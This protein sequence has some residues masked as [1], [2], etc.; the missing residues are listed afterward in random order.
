M[1]E[2]KEPLL[3]YQEFPGPL[4]I[5][6]GPGTGK[7]Y[8]LAMRVKFLLEDLE[9]DPNEIAVITF[10]NEAARNMREKLSEEDIDIPKEKH[11]EIISTMHSL[12]NAIIMANPEKFGFTKSPEVLYDKY[13]RKV[14][15]SDAANIA[16]YRRSKW[17][18]ADNCRRD[19]D[20]E[21]NEKEEKCKICKEYRTIMRKCALIDYDD[22]IMLACEILRKDGNLRDLWK[23]RTRYLLVD[24]YQDINKAQCEFIQLLSENQEDGLFVVGDDDQSIYSFRGG[25]PRFIRDFKSYYGDEF[26]IGRL[27]LSWRCPEHILMGARNVIREF[28]KESA[29]KP[30]PKFSEKIK[31]NNKIIFYDLPSERKEAGIITYLARERIKTDKIIIIIPN[32]NYLIPL[33]EALIRAGLDFKYKRTLKDKGLTRFTVLADWVENPNDSQKL[34]YLLDLIINNH[35]ELIE[36]YQAKDN[37]LTVRREEAS[38]FIAGLWKEVNHNKSFYQVLISMPNKHENISFISELQSTLDGLIKSLAEGGNRRSALPIF[39]QQ[40]GL[41]VAPGENPNGL[42]AEIEEWRIELIGSYRGR[43]FSPIHIYNLPSSKGLEADVIFVVG[44]SEGLFPDPTR[45]IEEQSRLLYVA[46]TRA[47][48]ELFLLSTR[49]RSAK[50][51]FKP[52]SF[53]LKRSPFIDVIP[54][55][56]LEIRYIKPSKKR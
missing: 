46:M 24:E 12:G 37:K 27:S 18:L 44:L 30:N 17:K 23:K 26:K 9:A 40:C 19:G 8:Q 13:P 35:D 38:K 36:K 2:I 28:Y 32:V 15:L 16:G 55:E 29:Q 47:K 42:L 20:C 50:I 10:T 7:T 6:S 53:Q 1:I 51:T 14:L 25:N 31:T 11:P 56:H 3:S 41:C 52:E 39:L 33:K 5:L 49:I 22:Q 48:K 21:E 43:S 45:D 4:L 34:R 54:N